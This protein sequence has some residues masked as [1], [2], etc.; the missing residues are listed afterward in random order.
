VEYPEGAFHQTVNHGDL[1]VVLRLK[2]RR[3][4]RLDV[5]G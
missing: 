5:A 3:Q 2:P 4:C 1:Q